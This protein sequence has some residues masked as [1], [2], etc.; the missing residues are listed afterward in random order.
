M[1]VGIQAQQ[2]VHTAVDPLVEHEEVVAGE[3]DEPDGR[4]PPEAGE[5]RSRQAAGDGR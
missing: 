1:M 3:P 4:R 2:D 5:G